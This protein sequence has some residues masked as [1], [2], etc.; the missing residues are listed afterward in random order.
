[1]RFW[2]FGIAVIWPSGILGYLVLMPI[3]LLGAS[4]WVEDMLGLEMRSVFILA[5]FLMG[6]VFWWALALTLLLWHRRKLLATEATTTH[7]GATGR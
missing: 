2:V 7:T 3:E 5:V 4:P 6:I 1:M